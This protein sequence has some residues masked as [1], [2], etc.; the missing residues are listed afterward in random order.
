MNLFTWEPE[1]YTIAFTTQSGHLSG[2][3][4][5]DINFR[6]PDIIK[7]LK[8]RIQKNKPNIGDIVVVRNYIFVILRKH[9]NTRINKTQFRDIIKGIVPNILKETTMFK[10]TSQDF[11]LFEEDL[12]ELIPNIEIRRESGWPGLKK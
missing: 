6:R 11:P 7:T 2:K 10:T 12:V 9:Y 5:K 1:R 4:M 8:T 3:L